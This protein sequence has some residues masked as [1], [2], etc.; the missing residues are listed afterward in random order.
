VVLKHHS[1]P[2]CKILVTSSEELFTLTVLKYW[3][4]IYLV[5]E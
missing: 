1:S 4:P 5:S 2:L 3:W